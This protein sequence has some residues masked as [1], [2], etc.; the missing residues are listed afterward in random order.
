MKSI[1]PSDADDLIFANL[2]KVESVDLPLINC[3]GRILRESIYADRP[4]PPFNRAMMDGYAIRSTDLSTVTG[5]DIIAELPAGAPPIKIGNA[6]G[7]FFGGTAGRRTGGE[8]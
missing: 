5:F 2:P 3:A 7:M 4:F 8:R 1:H 6:S